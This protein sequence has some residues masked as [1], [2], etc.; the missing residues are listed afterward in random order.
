VVALIGHSGAGKSTT[1][2]L[3][4]RL[5]DPAEGAVLID[6]MDI[7]TFTLGSLRSQIG[8]VLQD[9]VLFSG[10]VAENIAY[11]R[12]DATIEEVMEAARKANAHEFIADLPEGYETMLGERA[13]NLSGGQRQRIAIARAFIRGAPI[14]ILDEPTTGLDSLATDQVVKGLR[15][16][17]KGKTTI[18][19]SHNLRLIRSA[20]RVLV[21]EGGRIVQSGTHDELS[22]RPGAYAEFGLL[23]ASGPDGGLVEVAEPVPNGALVE[24]AEPVPNGAD[25]LVSNGVGSEAKDE[26]V[27]V[28]AAA[29][30]LLREVDRSRRIRRATAAQNGSR[31][32]GASHGPHSHDHPDASGSGSTP[33]PNT[34]A[35]S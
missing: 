6:G 20:D 26:G 11:G 34:Q 18:I 25:E 9:T 21:I 30:Q 24:V 28:K 32:N 5:Y 29:R 15:S 8:V 19:I 10:T 4:P 14:L 13:A 22:R 7:R 2:Q 27:G 33:G 17:I 12:E 31:T 23:D 35:G 16:L 1:A 3:I